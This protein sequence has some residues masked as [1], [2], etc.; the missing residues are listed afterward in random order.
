[1]K[2]RSI[3]S[4]IR[5]YIKKYPDAKPKQIAESLGLNRHSVYNAMHRI[6]VD[7]QAITKRNK[8]RSSPPSSAFIPVIKYDEIVAVRP[9]L[10][11]PIMK[12]EPEGWAGVWRAIKKAI[13]R[14]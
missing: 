4:R 8:P 5:A 2:K 12:P 14:R 11:E 7:A 13:W 10:P 6:R 3:T 1:M 9:P